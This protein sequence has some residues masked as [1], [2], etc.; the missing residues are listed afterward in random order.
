MTRLKRNAASCFLRACELSAR[1][2][3]NNLAV[4]A[5]ATGFQQLENIYGNRKLAT[6]WRRGLNEATRSWSMDQFG[7]ENPNGSAVKKMPE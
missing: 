2:G 4:Y 3:A 1:S 5:A 7:L 6:S